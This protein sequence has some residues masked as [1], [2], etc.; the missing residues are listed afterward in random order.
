M[1]MNI[2]LNPEVLQKY[3]T[4]L[5]GF[6]ILNS[7]GYKSENEKNEAEERIVSKVL[8]TFSDVNEIENHYLNDLYKSFYKSMG[9]KPKK[10]STPI[11]QAKRIIQN[12][13]Y[14]SIHKLIDIC[15]EVEYTYLVS[16]QVYDVDKINGSLEY[17]LSKGT[18]IIKNF[19]NEDKICKKDELILVDNES[20]AHSVY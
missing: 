11:K 9:L 10:V 14:R 5:F 7:D 2:T 19:H 17:Q 6:A 12:R 4:L 18:E 3:P 15:M 13:A 8:D 1:N 16:F 20:P